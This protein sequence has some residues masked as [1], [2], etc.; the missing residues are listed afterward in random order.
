V[1]A[2]LVA[3]ECKVEL[4]DVVEVAVEDDVPDE[5]V[6]EDEPEFVDPELFLINHRIG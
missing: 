1:P 3:V 4:P 2:E 5:V 6:E